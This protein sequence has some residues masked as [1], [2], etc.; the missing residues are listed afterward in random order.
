MIDLGT[1]ASLSE[2]RVKRIGKVQ[3][4]ALVRQRDRIPLGGKDHDVISVEIEL[5]R[6]EEVHGARVR[7]LQ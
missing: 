1:D 4:G 7:I 5:D 3:R 2:C 6:V